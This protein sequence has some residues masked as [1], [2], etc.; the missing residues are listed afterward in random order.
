[1]RS[2][3]GLGLVIG[4]LG[5]SSVYAGPIT[6]LPP[7]AAASS[8]APAPA[9]APSSASATDTSFAAGA[10]FDPV[11]APLLRTSGPLYLQLGVRNKLRHAGD[12][13][14]SGDSGGGGY[15]GGAGGAAGPG[16]GPA[17]GNVNPQLPV[18]SNGEPIGSGVGP[19]AS[20]PEPAT[21]LLL[22]PAVA[23]ALRR[24]ARA[25]R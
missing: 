14:F 4:V 22:G 18:G 21:L 2:L 25:R 20:I 1:M 16:G 8:A 11:G 15:A 6:G 5:T 24:R 23:I 12:P 10:L 17:I 9:D 19:V 3:L 13:G 7:E